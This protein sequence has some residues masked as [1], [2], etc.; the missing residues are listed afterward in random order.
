VSR[1]AF[2]QNEGGKKRKTRGRGRENKGV[3]VRLGDTTKIRGRETGELTRY[4]FELCA[5][6]EVIQGI[7]HLKKKKYVLGRECNVQKYSSV[8]CTLVGL[9]GNRRDRGAIREGLED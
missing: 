4:M 3:H 1:F 7:V 6:V 2:H 9:P 5:K 8:V